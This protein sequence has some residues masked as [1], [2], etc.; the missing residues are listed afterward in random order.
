MFLAEGLGRPLQ[1]LR[2]AERPRIQIDVSARVI[3]GRPAEPEHHLQ[4][5][6]AQDHA[7]SGVVQLERA[8]QGG[9]VSSHKTLPDGVIEA[10]PQGGPNVVAGFG[11]DAGSMFGAKESVDVLRLQPRQLDAAQ[12]RNDVLPQK[13]A[14][15]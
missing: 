7:R 1:R 14:I 5:L 3:R 12:G 4:L 15:A 10:G 6:G 2:D 9:R 13:L 11:G 8:G